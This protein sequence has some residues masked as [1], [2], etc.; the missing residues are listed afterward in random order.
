MSIS[1]H[2]NSAWLV[3]HNRLLSIVVRMIT[4]YTGT[5]V[6]NVKIPNRAAQMRV[7]L[8]TYRSM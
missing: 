5:P 4:E 2:M 1:P 7:R 6:P 3:E 8:L